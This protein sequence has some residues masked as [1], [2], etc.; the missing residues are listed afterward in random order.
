MK[1][2]L[3]A[4]FAVAGLLASPSYGQPTWPVSP[5]PGQTYEYLDRTLEFDGSI[6]RG[7]GGLGP[8]VNVQVFNQGETS[9]VPSNG[10]RYAVVHLYGAGGGGGGVE[11]S[12]SGNYGLGGCGGAG[13]Y[14]SSVIA[15]PTTTVIQVGAGGAGGD[16]STATDGQAGTST[17][18]AAAAG[19][20]TAGGGGGATNGT[21]SSSA[22]LAAGGAGGTASGGTVNVNGAA[23]SAVRTGSSL[24]FMVP[25]SGAASAWGSGGT[26]VAVSGNGNNGA[27]YG[28]GGSGGADTTA[29][30]ADQDGGN[31][32]DGLLVVVEYLGE[33]YGTSGKMGF[34]GETIWFSGSTCPT[35]TLPK[36]GATVSRATYNFLWAQVS[37]D[38]VA[39][40]TD[41]QYGTGDG[42]TTFVLPSMSNQYGW[43]VS[44]LSTPA[45]YGSVLESAAPD[46]D[47][48]FQ[49]VSGIDGS[50]IL[51]IHTGALS[52]TDNTGN[53]AESLSES[54][55]VSSDTHFFEA[56]ANEPTYQD[57][58]D[59]IS[60][61]S[62]PAM[63]CIV[64]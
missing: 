47:G 44:A 45:T 27:A 2:F 64:Y 7:I 23:G 9:Y 11:D 48:S 22:N 33:S 57:A 40:P 35:G 61:P 32:A 14:A 41:A 46:I 17:T 63:P 1:R 36:N 49:S 12:G 24:G 6:W 4:L 58:V 55:G 38:A 18:F 51:N 59:E 52:K 31:G 3:L 13:A 10:T 39:S 53:I 30:N 29:A 56:S 8:G 34:P 19:T 28:S 26:Q 20:I 16:G 50:G 21:S 25:C 62:I 54:A 43:I 60:V 37:G 5:V 15:N 42:S